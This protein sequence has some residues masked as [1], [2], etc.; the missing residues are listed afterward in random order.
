MRRLARLPD[1]EDPLIHV[2]LRFAIAVASAPAL[3]LIGRVAEGAA[4]AER[5]WDQGWGADTEYGSRGQHLIALGHGLLLSGDIEGAR[6]VAEMAIAGCRE[7]H[8]TPPLLFFLDLAAWIEL[9]SGNVER[10]IA[11]FSETFEIATELSLATAMRAAQA[12]LAISHSHTGDYQSAD[13]AMRRLDDIPAVPG[14][15]ADAE[16]R[17]AEAWTAAAGGDLGRAEEV[18]SGLLG[19]MRDRGLATLEL[20]TMFDL[21]RLGVA[22]NVGPD[23]AAELATVAQG[24]L[25]PILGQAVVAAVSA[26]GETLDRSAGRLRETGIR[27]VGG[28]TLV[29]RRRSVGG[30]RRSAR[31]HRCV[32]SRR[33]DTAVARP[34]ANAGARTPTLRRPAHPSGNERSPRWPQPVPVTPRS[35]NDSWCR[36]ETVENPSRQT[37][38]ANWA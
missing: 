8:E 32:A 16:V 33:R 9:H 13:A 1:V 26:D 28:R 20:L 3:I 7:R 38:T 2:D 17:W 29:D 36:S 27:V 22:D 24:Y 37:P 5:S 18:L 6:F 10:A 23:R 14:P 15:R 11:Y 30:G 19:G 35:P 34:G 25:L 4:L 21:V 12:G 31:R